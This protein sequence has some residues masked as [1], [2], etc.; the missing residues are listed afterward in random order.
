MSELIELE[1]DWEATYWLL[2]FS[3]SI[4]YQK[5]LKQEAVYAVIFEF[6]TWS[7]IKYEH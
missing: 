7:L 3:L 5:H 6:H 2:Y 4:S 1:A